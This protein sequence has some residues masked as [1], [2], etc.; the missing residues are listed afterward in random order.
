MAVVCA[1]PKAILD[2]P[3][4]L[5][6]LETRGVP[7]DRGRAG[8][9]AGLL[10]PL[11]RDPAPASVAGHRRGGRARRRS[12]SG[13]GSVAG[14]SSASRSRRPT[15]S[16][17][18]SPGQAV[19]RGHRR[20]R[21]RRDRRAGADAL[22]ARPDRGADRRRVG[23]RQHRAHR[24]RRAGRG[25]AGRPARDGLTRAT[26][27]RCPGFVTTERSSA[28]CRSIG[29]SLHSAADPARGRWT[30]RRDPTACGSTR[31]APARISRRSSARS[32]RSSISAG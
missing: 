10:R 18:T 13:S 5:E 26:A 32:E 2:V 30:A 31:A 23:P 9:P 27:A 14:S 8:R 21:D 7:V 19:E 22:A 11:G 1:G 25:R 16:P 20:R 4:T 12:T 6:Y 15:R 3:A 24:Q 29:R 28:P 17:M